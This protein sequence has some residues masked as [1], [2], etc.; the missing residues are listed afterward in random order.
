[1]LNL[2]SGVQFDNQYFFKGV[3]QMIIV[4]NENGTYTLRDTYFNMNIANGT[5]IQMKQ[6][7]AQIDAC[8]TEQNLSIA[9]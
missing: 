6:L 1:M 3:K 9:A 4:K 5:L 8:G 2:V 7:K